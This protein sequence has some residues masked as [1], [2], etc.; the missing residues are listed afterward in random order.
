MKME[1]SMKPKAVRSCLFTVAWL[2]STQALGEDFD[3]S[4]AL[5]CAPVEAIDCSP[6][7]DCLR[8]TPDD[9]GAPNFIR[10]DFASK[11]ITSAKR[12]TPIEAMSQADGQVL[13][14]GTELGYGWTL[15][16]DYATGRMAA[17]LTDIDG[18]FVM[19][20]SCT[21]L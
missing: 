17:T 15:A 11:T 18:A 5:I 10:I 19:F 9:I 14:R 13:L 12:A 3:G 4:K 21:P 20:G 6:G 1:S 2:L 8:G 7:E 16:L